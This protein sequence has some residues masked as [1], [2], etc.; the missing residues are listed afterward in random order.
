MSRAGILVKF[1][2]CLQDLNLDALLGEKNTQQQPRWTSAH[3]DDLDMLVR[4][5]IQALLPVLL[6]RVNYPPC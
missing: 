1:A 6:G 4:R 5:R 3:D 2:G